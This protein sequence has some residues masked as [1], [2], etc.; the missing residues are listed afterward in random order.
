M[1]RRRFLTA[2]T[3][4]ASGCYVAGL[5]SC[6]DNSNTTNMSTEISPFGNRVIDAHLHVR[7]ESI[8]RCLRVMDENN[9]HWGMNIGIGGEN[10]ED[11]Q[12]AYKT[13]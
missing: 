10:F 5:S 4:I 13:A 7:A 12:K 1:H 6:A 8:E 11:F 2:T 9:I 3:A